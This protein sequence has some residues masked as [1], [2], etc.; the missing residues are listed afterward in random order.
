MIYINNLNLMFISFVK[1]YLN[2]FTT[3]LVFDATPE[4]AFYIK[5]SVTTYNTCLIFMILAFFIT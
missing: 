2:Y 3:H 4:I 5:F 1:N